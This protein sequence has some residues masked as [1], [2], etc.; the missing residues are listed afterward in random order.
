MI[1]GPKADKEDEEPDKSKGKLEIR[2]WMLEKDGTERANKGIVFM[3][4][5]GPHQ[6]TEIMVKNNYG[7]TKEILKSVLTRDNFKDSVV[8]L[9]SEDDSDEADGNYF[10]MRDMLLS[11]SDNS[12]DKEDDD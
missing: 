1:R 10:D 12:G 8:N 4:E 3:T 9:Y 6:L 7:D 11:Y 2:K 5:E